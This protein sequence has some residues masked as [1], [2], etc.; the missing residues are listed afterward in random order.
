MCDASRPFFLIMIYV[1]KEKALGSYV[2]Y[3]IFPPPHSRNVTL[4]KI[5]AYTF[6]YCAPDHLTSSEPEHQ[7]PPV[8]AMYA[9]CL[10]CSAVLY[11]NNC[12][13]WIFY[14]RNFL[15]TARK[16]ITDGFAN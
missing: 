8:S 7:P 10:L 1:V 9:C 3:H 13:F 14:C 12:N 16:L 6:H 15:K 11:I 2:R 4:P 5:C